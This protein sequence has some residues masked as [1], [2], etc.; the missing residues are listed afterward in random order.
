MLFIF[1]TQYNNLKI[2]NIGVN[3]NFLRRSF[4]RKETLLNDPGETEKNTHIKEHN[5]LYYP[6][7]N[8]TYK[9]NRNSITLFNLDL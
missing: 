9:M 6:M 1:S 7:E 2:R 3:A 8:T 5:L 4:G